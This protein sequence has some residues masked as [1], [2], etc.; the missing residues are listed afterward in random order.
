MAAMKFGLGSRRVR[1]NAIGAVLLVLAMAGYMLFLNVEDRQL[2][3][4]DQTLARTDFARY[5]EQ[6][7]ATK[8]FAVYVAAFSKAYGW[9]SWQKDVPPFLLG[10]WALDKR[11]RRVN[12]EYIPT[13][14]IDALVIEDGWLK[15]LGS[16]QSARTV[17]YRIDGDTVQARASNG[18]IIPIKL[19]SYDVNL[20]H[21]EVKL[22]GYTDTLYGYQCR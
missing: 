6:L 1:Y 16:S 22:P 17:T 8:G 4:R 18:S 13:S 14:C 9:D 2:A 12:D 19:V 7:R 11:P 10:R 5:L 21:I 15:T 20:H 3:Q